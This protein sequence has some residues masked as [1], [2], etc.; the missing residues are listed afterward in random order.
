MDKEAHRDT[1]VKNVEIAPKIIDRIGTLP[2]TLFRE[3][4]YSSENE[5]ITATHV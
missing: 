1:N 2:H 3:I 4:L 5:Q